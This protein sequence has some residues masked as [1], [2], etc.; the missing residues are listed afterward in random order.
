MIVEPSTPVYGT[1]CKLHGVSQHHLHDSGA[2]CS[3]IAYIMQTTRM[4]AEPHANPLYG[5]GAPCNHLHGSGAW[6]SL[7]LFTA[8]YEGR[9]STFMGQYS[10]SVKRLWKTTGTEVGPVTYC[11]DT[12]RGGH[13]R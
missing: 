13:L 1:T 8:I 9:R 6:L 12:Q 4:V 5:S 3:Y 11:M 10:V 7:L 2:A